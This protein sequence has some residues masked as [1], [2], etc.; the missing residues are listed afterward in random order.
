[1]TRKDCIVIC[2]ILKFYLTMGLPMSISF[3]MTLVSILFHCC[4]IQTMQGRLLLF[5]LQIVIF[6]YLLLTCLPYSFLI[7]LKAPRYPLVG[8]FCYQ[9]HWIC[10]INLRT[11]LVA[12]DCCMLSKYGLQR[13]PHMEIHA[14]GFII[15]VR[16]KNGGRDFCVEHVSYCYFFGR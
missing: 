12:A 4:D 7:L 14:W 10:C 2:A 9:Y 1:M 6:L 16:S 15:E 11:G 3:I 8:K 13:I 5:L